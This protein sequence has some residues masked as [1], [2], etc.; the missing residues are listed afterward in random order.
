VTPRR[1]LLALCALAVAA[2]WGAPGGV[3]GQEAPGRR[4]PAGEDVL[5]VVGGEIHTGTGRTIRRGTVLC[6]GGKIDAIGV[7][8]RIPEGATVVDAT[9]KWVLP[10]F[11]APRGANMGIRR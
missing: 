11:V 10:G 4:P 2:W 5:A 7:D 1:R 3:R 8:L 6:R 9:G